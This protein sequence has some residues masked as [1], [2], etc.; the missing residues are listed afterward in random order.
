MHAIGGDDDDDDDDDEDDDDDDG[1]LEK[2]SGIGRANF[3]WLI[4]LPSETL[5]TSLTQFVL[6]S[7]KKA[8]LFAVPKL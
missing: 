4:Y 2:F 1:R 6:T 5:I 8:C 3:V 7:I